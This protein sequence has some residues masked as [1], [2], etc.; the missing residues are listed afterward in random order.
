MELQ[1]AGRTV[2]S[3]ERVPSAVEPGE[4]INAAASLSLGLEVPPLSWLLRGRCA[5]VR[6]YCWA[7]RFSGSL[8]C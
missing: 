5:G 8:H 1:R 7:A 4:E 6:S 3:K 2:L